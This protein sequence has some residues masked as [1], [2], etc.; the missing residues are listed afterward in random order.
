MRLAKLKIKQV[1][2][3][4]ENLEVEAGNWTIQD[5]KVVTFEVEHKEISKSDIEKA[6]D[7]EKKILEDIQKKIEEDLVNFTAKNQIR[8][9][10]HKFDQ[11]D[12]MVEITKSDEIFFDTSTSLYLKRQTF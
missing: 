1:K 2:D 3:L 5:G 11:N 4:S 8:A 12:G 9:G 10:Y 7:L 6:S